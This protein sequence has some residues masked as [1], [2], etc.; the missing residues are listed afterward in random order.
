M[1]P[2]S[3][4]SAKR[5]YFVFMPK[6]HI[7][8]I[9]SN[10]CL[11]HAHSS[12]ADFCEILVTFVLHSGF[13]LYM[14][15]HGMSFSRS[16][17]CTGRKFICAFHQVQIECNDPELTQSESNTLC[18]LSCWWDFS[19]DVSCWPEPWSAKWGK[20]QITEVLRKCVLIICIC[21]HTW[22]M[23]VCF[24]PHHHVSDHSLTIN[25]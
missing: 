25:L 2:Y 14:S 9:A 23:F 20:G 11:G 22:Q 19:V 15:C 5:S 1:Y 7:P 4:L 17:N 6:A 21:M 24:V 8:Y 10:E 18:V 13:A 12:K 16:Y 3:L